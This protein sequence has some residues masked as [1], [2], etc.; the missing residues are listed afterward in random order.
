MLPKIENRTYQYQGNDIC[1]ILA[2]LNIYADDGVT[3]VSSTGLFA[4]YNIAQ[5]DFVDEIR[6]Q[7][8]FQVQEYLNK[9]LDLDAKR[10]ARVPD[11]TSFAHAVDLIINPI[12][13]AIGG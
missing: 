11:S 2:T 8:S 1:A 5:S 4:S 13:T 3:L 6:R 10:L 9:L 12:Q 7:L